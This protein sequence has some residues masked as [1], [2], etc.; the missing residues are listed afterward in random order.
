[1]DQIDYIKASHYWNQVSTTIS[2]VYVMDGFGFP[3]N[4][5][6]NRFHAECKVVEKLMNEKGVDRGH[7]LD[8]GC[9]IGLW[10][11]YFS[12]TFNKVTGIEASSILFH[13]ASM[14]CIEES[15]IKLLLDDV[16]L[17]KPEGKYSVIFIGGLLMYLNEKDVVNLLRLIAPF[18]DV[19]GIILCRETTLY[20]DGVVNDEGY[21]VVYRSV[22]TY[23]DIFK[24]CS[25]NT[26]KVEH[27]FPY[28]LAQV[29]CEIMKK[30]KRH[31]PTNMQLISVIGRLVY[32]GVVL[33]APWIK[34]HSTVNNTKFPRLRNKFFILKNGNKG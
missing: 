3:S 22:D 24:Q 25:L 34:Y 30:W 28:H 27:N 9:G 17:F 10:T 31:C 29:A 21:H 2:G 33:L 32:W 6:E 8:L 20:K 19:G 18:L 23:K 5:A 13:E 14:R 15:N 1:M 26:V 12:K 11:K 7:L 4:A 16:L